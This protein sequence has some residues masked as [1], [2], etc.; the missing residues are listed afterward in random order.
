[1][2]SKV[3]TIFKKEDN[4]KLNQVAYYFRFNDKEEAEKCKK[5]LKNM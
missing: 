4:I 5:M 1:M 3:K 2:D